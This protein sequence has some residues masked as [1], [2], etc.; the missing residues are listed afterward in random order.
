MD[1][2][3]GTSET[4]RVIQVFQPLYSEPLNEDDAREIAANL[5]GYFALLAKWHAAE[6]QSKSDEDDSET[7][8]H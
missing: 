7:A 6:Q 8:V 3:I 5:N 2:G 1:E 4:D